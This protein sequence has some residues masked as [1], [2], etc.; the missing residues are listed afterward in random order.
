MKIERNENMVDFLGQ[1]VYEG[2]MLTVVAGYGGDLFI[3]IVKH[4]S[5]CGIFGPSFWVY[6][7]A[8]IHDRLIDM[9]NRVNVYCSSSYAIREWDKGHH[10]F[11]SRILKIDPAKILHPSGQK[12]YNIILNK[13]DLKENEPTGSIRL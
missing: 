7:E 11:S 8:D 5:E 4:F 13:L 3:Q 9:A 6:G 2:D 1:P 12:A 10:N